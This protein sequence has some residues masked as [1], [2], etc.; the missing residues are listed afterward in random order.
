MEPK[1][2]TIEELLKGSECT[3]YTCNHETSE[4]HYLV[5]EAFVIEIVTH[6]IEAHDRMLAEKVGK[7]WDEVIEANK[8]AGF[9][10]YKLEKTRDEVLS[11][12][13][14]TKYEEN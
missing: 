9:G 14:P 6:A 10:V 13:A 7:Y 12:L 8:E 3:G 4:R 11:L 5:D 1:Q 2:E